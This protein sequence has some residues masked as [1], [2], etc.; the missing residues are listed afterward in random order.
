MEKINDF[1]KLISDEKVVAALGA[2]IVALLT[3]MTRALTYVPRKFK[4]KQNKIANQQAIVAGWKRNEILSGLL[5]VGA[6]Y[7]LLV[8]YHN[9]GGLLK[10]SRFIYMSVDVEKLGYVCMKC[11]GNCQARGNGFAKSIAKDW[12]NFK[13]YN[14]D[15]YFEW[16]K[17][18]V[19]HD[20]KVHSVDIEQMD[21]N[22]KMLNASYG[23]YAVREIFVKHADNRFYTIL[24]AFCKR[25]RNIDDSINS[26]IIMA[27]NRMAPLV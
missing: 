16:I 15:G 24:L 6:V 14:T 18:V 11:M 13:I 8:R 10:N 21:T 3:Y 5:D 19:V 4:E 25:T 20:N 12:Q 23:I 17:D 9:G 2:L 27:A 26:Q 22:G 1:W 7:V